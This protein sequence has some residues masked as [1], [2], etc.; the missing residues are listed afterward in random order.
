MGRP[1]NWASLLTIVSIIIYQTHNECNGV[2]GTCACVVYML[3][4]G[5]VPAACV[6]VGLLYL[7]NP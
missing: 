1:G 5:G 2:V 4:N 6:A 3:N 7:A